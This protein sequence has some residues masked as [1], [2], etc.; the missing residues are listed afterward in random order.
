[1]YIIQLNCGNP[2]SLCFLVLRYNIRKHKMGRFIYSTS[3]GG[4]SYCN[5]RFCLCLGT[6][7]FLKLSCILTLSYSKYTYRHL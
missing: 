7:F 3:M 5:H 1:M 4:V 6:I 2:L